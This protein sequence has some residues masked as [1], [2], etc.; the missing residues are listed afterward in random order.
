MTPYRYAFG[1]GC[2][3]L[4]LHGWGLDSGVW[5]D[6]QRLLSAYYRVTTLDLPG[7]GGNHSLGPAV[8]L[9]A[10]VEAVAAVI[11]EPTVC[12]G[13][14]LGGMV[15]MAAALRYPSKVRALILVA[16]TPC[17]VQKPDWPYGLPGRQLAAFAEG[18]AS[19][20]Q[21]TL[22][23]F[24]TLQAGQGESARRV[25]KKFRQQVLER[26][27]VDPSVLQTGLAVLQT[28]DLRPVLHTIDCPTLMF[29]GGRD[30]LVPA[31]VSDALSV[32]RP[33][34]F[35]NI[36]ANS[37]HAPFISH[38]EA[39]LARLQVFLDEVCYGYPR[40]GR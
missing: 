20:Y 6:T 29:F 26:A 19:D 4:A 17:F 3:V 31:A 2:P 9:E 15:A 21:G 35:G 33:N 28:T 27:A 24:L 36:L 40:N 16:S 37:G 8:G 25:I 38:Q 23:R 1:Q 39:F 22:L 30:V 18:L 13:W 10:M 34:W 14:S 11:T 32:L 5:R 12:M 7:Y